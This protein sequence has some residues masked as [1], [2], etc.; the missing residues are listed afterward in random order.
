[1]PE[2]GCAV[3]G[4]RRPLGTGMI[5][6]ACGRLVCQHHHQLYIEG[7]MKPDFLKRRGTVRGVPNQYRLDVDVTLLD[8]K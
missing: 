2:D 4:C 8:G 1:M 7:G 6:Q 3:N 5:Y